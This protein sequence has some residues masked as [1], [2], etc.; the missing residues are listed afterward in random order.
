[1]VGLLGRVFGREASFGP[2]RVAGVIGVTILVPLAAG[3]VLRRFAPQWA[4][5]AAL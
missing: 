3:L 1:M 5:Y 2:E 4:G